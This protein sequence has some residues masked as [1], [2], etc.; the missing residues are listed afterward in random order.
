[1]ASGMPQ[2]SELSRHHYN[3]TEIGRSIIFIGFIM[4]PLVRDLYKRAIS[5]GRD[6][7]LGLDYVRKTWK[8]ALRDPK[9]CPSCYADNVHGRNQHRHHESS[10]GQETDDDG[11][12]SS[13]SSSLSTSEPYVVSPE[14]ER[15][16]R[17]AVGRGRFMIREMVALVQL[18]KYRS[19]NQRYNSDTTSSGR[20][21]AELKA[22]LSQRM[23][24]AD[25]SSKL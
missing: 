14:C 22:F 17:K 15:E 6:Y 5:V 16:L 12:V 13:S 11:F 19:M 24:D 25:K 2:L 9:N 1:M 4:H 8:K 23:Q 18:K 20:T 7:P 21:T 3:L 10:S